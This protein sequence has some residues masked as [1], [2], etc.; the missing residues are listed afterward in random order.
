[1]DE[2]GDAKEAPKEEVRNLSQQSVK[3]VMD[4]K[5]SDSLED[6]CGPLGIQGEVDE[7]AEGSWA[8]LVIEHT[9]EEK[10]P[11]ECPS[12]KRQKVPTKYKL[13]AP[14]PAEYYKKRPSQYGRLCLW[15]V[16]VS[17]VKQLWESEQIQTE[18]VWETVHKITKVQ[19]SDT[20]QSR[21]EIYVSLSAIDHITQVLQDRKIRVKAYKSWVERKAQEKDDWNNLEPEVE[22]ESNWTSVTT[23]SWNTG[24]LKGKKGDLK[25]LLGE[26]IDILGLQETRRAKVQAPLKLKGYRVF[27]SVAETWA[28]P[29]QA[30]GLAILVRDSL[31]ASLMGQPKDNRMWVRIHGYPTSLYICCVYVPQNNHKVK[32][33]LLKKV[34]KEATSYGKRGEVAVMG[35]FNLT[36]NQL[37]RLKIWKYA[38]LKACEHQGTEPPVTNYPKSGK[39]GRAID[40]IWLSWNLQSSQLRVLQE[41][42]KSEHRPVCTTITLKREDLNQQLV[43]DER[44]PPLRPDLSN[45]ELLK[46]LV[47]DQRWQMVQKDLEK[48]TQS[49]L[50]WIDLQL[51]VASFQDTSRRIHEDLCGNKQGLSGDTMGGKWPQIHNQEVGRKR[52]VESLLAGGDTV[53]QEEWQKVQAEKRMTRQELETKLQASYTRYVQGR[54]RRGLGKRQDKMFYQWLQQAVNQTKGK[55]DLKGD[56]GLVIKDEKNGIL[57][58][59]PTRALEV[60]AQHCR[61]VCSDPAPKAE[62]FWEAQV[63]KTGQRFSPLPDKEINTPFTWKEIVGTLRTRLNGKSPRD[64]DGITWEWLKATMVS[65]RED[66]EPPNPMAKAVMTLANLVWKHGWPKDWNVAVLVQIPKKGDL[67]IM[68]NYRG[69]A[70]IAVVQKLICAMLAQRISVALETRNRIYTGQGGF[71][72]KEEAIE[73]VVC[74]HEIKLRRKRQGEPTY[75][76]FIDFRKAY[77]SVPHGALIAKLSAIGVHGRSLELVRD[78]YKDNRLRVRVSKRLSEEIPYERGVR[79]GCP[80]SPLLFNIFINDILLRADR[81]GEGVTVPGMQEPIPGLL[82]ADDLAVVANTPEQLKKLL[83]MVEEWA[84]TW[85]MNFGHQK[86]A[87]VGTKFSPQE[88]DKLCEMDN[89]PQRRRNELQQFLD[90]TQLLRKYA[91]WRFQNGNFDIKTSYKYLG[92]TLTE[93][94]EMETF[95]AEKLA[96]LKEALESLVPILESKSVP[97]Y[98][99]LIILRLYVLSKINYGSEILVREK[100]DAKPFQTLISRGLRLCLNLTNWSH[101]VDHNLWRE[102]NTPPV[103]A[104][105]EAA[106]ARL[107]VKA[108]S[109]KSWIAKLAHPE[110]KTRSA[111][112]KATLARTWV[113]KVR[114]RLRSRKFGS[115]DCDLFLTQQELLLPLFQRSPKRIHRAVKMGEWRRVTQIRISSQSTPGS[116]YKEFQF[117]ETARE[118]RRAL[119]KPDVNEDGIRSL[120]HLRMG[121]FR[122]PREEVIRQE[123]NVPEDKLV[124]LD[125]TCPICSSEVGS[126]LPRLHH[127]LFH[128]QGTTQFRQKSNLDKLQKEILIPLA[129][130]YMPTRPRTAQV[131]L[132]L[133]GGGKEIHQNILK[134]CQRGIKK[135]WVRIMTEFLSEGIKRYDSSLESALRQAAQ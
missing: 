132:A 39:R 103:H 33:V 58:T 3:E 30:R 45:V 121:V 130:H 29:G 56:A 59:D 83:K 89:A 54:L 41:Y 95:R 107:L 97:T 134:Q 127:I 106:A 36:A 17:T 65:E 71:R 117:G 48:A 73:H 77:D 79:Q 119:E 55:V 124:Q 75:I 26:G 67:Q 114:T 133:G 101:R 110:A 87:I 125:K 108:P 84:N 1:M 109:S 94:G 122:M 131:V 35:D 118:L 11:S 47:E 68:D 44:V 88:V 42:D 12:V 78:L 2:K 46:T 10:V 14:L 64:F 96:K 28:K 120:M 70:L 69:I 52:K 43:N 16:P 116:R 37:V 105:W 135:T 18:D 129:R 115:Q 57:V 31:R 21:F 53:Q 104:I 85:G 9:A 80:L 23:A 51:A 22:Q 24:S 86:C 27:E 128:C 32:K 81:E 91:P 93:D 92:V 13:P 6:E 66:A 90:P 76:A 102:T 100:E 74:L 62:E 25:A 7:D 112:V 49:H 113:D 4:L 98:A 38:R 126:L 99:R 123:T 34:T 60:W 63:E 72:E 8:H 50:P 82:F 15:D 19:E 5:H 61:E 111:R 20:G 40:Q